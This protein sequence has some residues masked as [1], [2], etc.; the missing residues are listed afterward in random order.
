VRRTT[1][2]RLSDA[3]KDGNVE[4]VRQ[5]LKLH[6]DLVADCPWLGTWI[7][8]AAE[9]DNVA[10]VAMLVEEFGFDVNAPLGEKNA[11]GPLSNAAYHGCVNVACWLLDHGAK[12]DAP[13]ANPPIP[14]ASAATGGSLEVARL[15]LERGAD[16]NVVYGTMEYGDPPTNALRQALLFGHKEIAALLRAHGAV[17]PPGC[18]LGHTFSEGSGV[19]EHIERHLGKP[20]PLSLHEIVP[21]NPPITIHVVPMRDCLA[22]V[23][24]GMS[25]RAMTVPQ[26]GEV[27]QFAELLIYL[28]P[29]WPLT[30]EALQDVN[31]SWPI[32]WL[33]R[34]AY[35]P[36]DNRT[37]LGGIAAVIA[38][39]E[40]PQPLAP[41]TQMTCLLVLAEDSII[42]SV[43]LPGGR[44]VLF[45]TLYP[46]YTE[47]RDLEREKG[48]EALLG[49]L[50][51]HGIGKIVDVH[52]P[53]VARDTGVWVPK[54]SSR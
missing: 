33:R 31:H 6:P 11:D 10:M 2:G 12:V 42:N 19:L 23:T 20:D 41:N 27:F 32:Q 47:E 13:G 35:Y 30:K 44:R 14:L 52:R 28:P 49:L 36:H 45:Y 54:T 22:L 4:E 46:L 37:W 16:P 1:T 50:Q 51:S 7:H 25:D 38:N 29:T 34:I 3:I 40:P 9:F 5:L 8:H 43:P 39:G 17:L 21:G 18:D 15:L 53:N 26:G 24:T 48:T